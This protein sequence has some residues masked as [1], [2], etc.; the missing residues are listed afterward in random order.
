MTNKFLSIR[1]TPSNFNH[2]LK[3][4]RVSDSRKTFNQIL[5]KIGKQS[6]TILKRHTPVSTGR[7]RNSMQV[8]SKN[9]ASGIDLRSGIKIGS[10]LP[11]A[12]WVDQGTKASPGRYVPVL[13]RRVT[14]GTH[15]GVR[16]RHY[17]EA[18]IPNIEERT[19]MLLERYEKDW[20]RSLR[21]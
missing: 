5:D 2:L 16:P 21:L 6:I 14:T 9:N 4:W 19:R 11:Y 18:A 13:G 17:V 7:L 8:L 12:T 1:V 3:Q 15:P 10:T 20:R